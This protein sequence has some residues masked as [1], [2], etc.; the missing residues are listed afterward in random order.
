MT[1]STRADA[2][3][4]GHGSRWNSEALWS[5]VADGASPTSAPTSASRAFTSLIGAAAN[6]RLPAGV[7]ANSSKRPRASAAAGSSDRNAPIRCACKGTE[8]SAEARTTRLAAIPSGAFGAHS[9][10]AIKIATRLELRVPGMQQRSDHAAAQL[11]P[12]RGWQRR[13]VR[14]WQR[15]VGCQGNLPLLGT[16]S[17]TFPGSMTG[18]QTS[19]GPTLC[20]CTQ[21]LLESQVDS[22]HQVQRVGVMDSPSVGNPNALTGV[23]SYTSNGAPPEVGAP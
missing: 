19:Q 4:A 3:A 22:C 7:P 2:I 6:C 20:I 17:S 13:R 15:D 23:T 8:Q 14:R 10:Q 11:S 5:T 16:Y 12:G 21:I 9:I 18:H 1:A